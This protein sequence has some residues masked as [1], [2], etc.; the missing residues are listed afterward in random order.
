[1]S[2]LYRTLAA[3][4]ALAT[5]TACGD[6]RSVNPVA[7][8]ADVRANTTTNSSAIT[9]RYDLIV[10]QSVRIVPKTTTRV[11]RLRWTSANANVASV[12]STGTVSA[13][14]AGI[15]IVTAASNGV[16]ENYEVVVV[17]PTVTS[18]SLQPKTG[19]TLNAGQTQQYATNTTWSDGQARPVSVTY[20]ATGGTISSTGLFTAG[21][22]AGTF[23]VIA[24]CACTTPAIAD[25]ALVSVV[26]PQLTSLT[27]SPKSLSMNAGATQ[28]FAVSAQWNTGAT[29]VPP[30]TWSAT[31][32]SVSATGL[33]SAP[34]V[35]G[36]YRVI[37]AH[38]NGTIRDTA[39]VTVTSVTGSST[40]TSSSLACPNEPAGQTAVLDR[41]F[42]SFPGAPMIGDLRSVGNRDT[43]TTPTAP[44]SPT[45]MALKIKA[46]TASG[47][48]GI[49][50]TADDYTN[51]Y[52]KAYSCVVFSQS[53]NYQQHKNATKFFY[54]AQL[55]LDRTDWKR[56][57]E[58]SM[59]PVGDV[60][61]GF[62]N[63]V[64]WTYA[65][66]SGPTAFGEN[67]NATPL[68]RGV[69]YRIETWAELGSPS[70]N[71]GTVRWWISTWNG[72]SW[73]APVLRGDH[74]GTVYTTGPTHSGTWVSW[75]IDS[76][77]GGSGGTPIPEDQYLRINRM[78][79]SMS[80]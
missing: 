62:F 66:G 77:F 52:T 79:V 14:A 34:T 69:W 22:L 56:P 63:F 45:S 18:F 25:T 6:D 5:L 1:M 40:P 67:V 54:P 41:A 30:V 53:E 76:Y 72:T 11:S 60:T 73:S 48:G 47:A 13:R 31:G 49:L 78:R 64:L 44:L 26:V 15:S 20:T 36:T 74:T 37:I 28:Q 21:N 58:L 51:N 17:P 10:G 8:I 27:V 38:T 43:M 57:F 70:T 42:G 39:V 24:T 19:V 71:Y 12:S 65:G 9:A 75:M 2:P 68:Q 61:S 7:D 3:V 59:R 29:T 55:T 23:M 32:G 35:S 33:Y 80:R 4:A 16:L 50:R 46:G